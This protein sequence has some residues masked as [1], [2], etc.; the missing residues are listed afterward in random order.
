MCLKSRGSISCAEGP[1]QQG[2][3]AGRYI[4]TVPESGQGTGSGEIREELQ[5]FSRKQKKLI[6]YHSVT[7]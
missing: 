2:W 4:R 1:E 3:K 7:I 6:Y 5:E